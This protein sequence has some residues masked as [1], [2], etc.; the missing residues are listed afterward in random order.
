M[1]ERV[2]SP[3]GNQSPAGLFWF[4]FKMIA[5]RNESKLPSVHLL[6]GNARKSALLPAYLLLRLRQSITL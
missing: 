3:A 2:K 1:S 6:P 5:H 4:F